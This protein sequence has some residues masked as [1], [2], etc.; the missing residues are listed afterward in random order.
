MF[1]VVLFPCRLPAVDH[2]VVTDD[3]RTGLCFSS[4]LRFQSLIRVG[5]EV[6]SDESSFFEI[7]LKEVAVV[8]VDLVRKI[9]LLNLARGGF[10]EVFSYLVCRLLLEKK[11]RLRCSSQPSMTSTIPFPNSGRYAVRSGYLCRS[12]N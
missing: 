1:V 12:W 5:C 2:E 11:K 9:E 4:Q 10:E 8:Y 7:G 3:S 6:E